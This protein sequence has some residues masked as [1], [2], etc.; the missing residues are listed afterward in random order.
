MGKAPPALSSSGPEP[1]AAVA[2]PPWPAHV[3]TPPPPPPSSKRGASSSFSDPSF[4]KKASS[5]SARIRGLIDQLSEEFPKSSAVMPSDWM[6]SPSPQATTRPTLAQRFVVDEGMGNLAKARSCAKQLAMP[7]LAARSEVMVAA[8]Q[9]PGL[10]GSGTLVD[11]VNLPEHDLENRPYLTK[12]TARDHAHFVNSTY[13]ANCDANTNS[14]IDV[15]WVCCKNKEPTPVIRTGETH[16]YASLH[17][18]RREDR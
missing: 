12:G 13:W 14:P 2:M 7:A 3:P 18:Y 15:G 17:T 8:M 9:G 5:D 11:D 1:K 4:P 16:C 6:P 10:I